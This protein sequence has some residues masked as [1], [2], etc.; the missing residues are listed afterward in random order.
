MPVADFYSIVHLGSQYLKKID[1]PES[2]T[3]SVIHLDTVCWLQLD[4]KFHSVLPGKYH[5]LW[6]MKLQDSY[7]HSS[8]EACI[9]YKA[10]PEEGCGVQLS[11]K[12]D[13]KTMRKQE[14]RN[15]TNKWFVYNTGEFIV[16]SMCDIHVEI[17]GRNDYWCGGFYWDYVQLK[18]VNNQSIE[19]KKNIRLSKDSCEVM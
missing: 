10:T 6:R 7:M 12:W 1:D 13:V 16:E 14:K 2:S 9:Y 11:C 4:G 8:G 3:G 17:H 5:V 19:T 15:G 18:Y